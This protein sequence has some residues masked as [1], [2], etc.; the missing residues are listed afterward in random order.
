MSEAKVMLLRES[1]GQELL[2]K[3]ISDTWDRWRLARSEREKEWEEVRRF[4]FATDTTKTGAGRAGWS[5]T[6][7]IPKLCQIRDNLHANYYSSEFASD[8]FTKWVAVGKDGADKA[9]RDAIHAYMDNKIRQSEFRKEMSLCLLDYIDYGNSFADVVYEKEIFYNEE[10]G[11]QLM[12][13]I[14]PR[15]VRIAPQDIVF[16]PLARS[17]KES[18]NIVRYLKDLGELMIEAEERPASGYDVAKLIDR[19]EFRNKLSGYAAEDIYKA[20]GFK[21]DGFGDMQEYFNSGLVELLVFEGN[22]YDEGTGTLQRN[23]RVVVADRTKVILNEPLRTSDGKTSKVM[24]GWRKRPDNLWG[25]GPLDN[26]VGMQYRIDHIENLKAD[27]FDLVAYPPIAVRGDVTEFKWKPNEII[28]LGED[29]QVDLLKVDSAVL[30]YNYEIQYYENK[31]EEMAGAPKQ[32]MGIRTPGEKTAYEVQTLENAAGR[33]FQAKT[34]QFSLEFIEPLLNNMLDCARRNMDQADVIR[35]INDEFGVEQFLTVTPEDIKV[36]GKI[37][38]VGAR[39]FTERAQMVQNLTGFFNSAMGQ[40]EM[41]KMHFS[42]KAIA[43]MIEDLFD[44]SSYELVKDHVRMEEQA[45]AQ[46][47]MT[48]IEENMAVEQESQDFVEV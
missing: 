48:Q 21:V 20:V 17:F 4:L 32:A 43:K 10:T 22:I 11:E 47:L 26:L 35:V 18:P 7:T 28:F 33:I 9:K 37:L 29:G 12:G 31:M 39:H 3:N 30:Q 6:T 23:R 36:K 24:V 16:N 13:Y 14:G 27:L 41:V 44:L 34:L 42:G 19:K 2:A 25:M 38:A 40:D 15:A 45:E 1:L 8:R 46:Q 5:N